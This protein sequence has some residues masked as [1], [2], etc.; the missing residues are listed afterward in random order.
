MAVGEESTSVAG[1]L[2]IAGSST[3]GCTNFVAIPDVDGDTLMTKHI[4][5]SVSH[6]LFF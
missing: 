3:T 6:F 4:T 2:G 5:D 1:A